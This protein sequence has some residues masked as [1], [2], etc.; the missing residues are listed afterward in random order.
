V[1][2]LC[3][4]GFNRK[5]A[6]FGEYPLPLRTCGH[7]HPRQPVHRGLALMILGEHEATQ[8]RPE[9]AS[10]AIRQRRRYHLAV[11]GLPTLALT[12]GRNTKSCTMKLVYPL[13]RAPGGGAASLILRS[14]LIDNF[15][16]VLPRR[17][18][19][20]RESPG[21]FGSLACS[22]PLGLLF[23]LRF[24]RGGP[25]LSRAISSRW[26]ATVL[27]SSATSC[28]SFRTKSL[29]SAGDRP[30]ISSGNLATRT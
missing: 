16:R 29:S 22:M 25:P 18:R 9:M 23:G 6:L 14:S 7:L 11:R 5:A 15:E 1:R 21:G 17:R 26:A 12:C 30:S 19:S 24:G 4:L 10:D 27:R 13:K 28:R 3:D 8:L 2:I 20:W